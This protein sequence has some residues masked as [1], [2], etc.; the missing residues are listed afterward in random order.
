MNQNIKNI[1]IIP[2]RK[3]SKGIKNKNIKN[4]N[5]KPLAYYTIKAALDSKIFSKIFVT[6]NSIFYKKNYKNF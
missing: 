3:G 5:G 2:I 4:F 6:H 1:C